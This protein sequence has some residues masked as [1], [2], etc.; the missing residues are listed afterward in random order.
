[1]PYDSS[2][3]A[4]VKRNIAVTGQTVLAEQVNVPF[5]DIQAMLSQVLLRSGVAPMTGPLNMNSHKILNVSEGTSPDDAVNYAQLQAVQSLISAATPTGTVQAFRRK[6]PPT[7]WVKENGGT[8]GNAASGATTR[9]N[10]DTSNLYAVLWSEFSNTELPIQTNTG[11]ATTRGASASADFSANKRL[12]LFDS[13]T[14]YLRSSDDG[15]GFDASLVVG[16]SQADGIKNHAH[17]G[18]TSPAGAHRHDYD[19]IAPGGSVG[20]GAPDDLTF[21]SSV[22]SM[23]GDHTHTVTTNSTTDGLTLET[24]PRSSVVLYC[25]KL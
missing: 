4:S 19:G 25:I 21:T 9:A 6:T 5:A 11:V 1:M 7:G 23:V 22:T 16:T 8:I 20:G 2:G 24:R 18:T 10:D 13:R 14:R 17:T 12:P 15:L 3:S